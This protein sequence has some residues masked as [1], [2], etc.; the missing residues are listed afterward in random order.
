MY[1]YNIYI[2]CVYIIY[3]MYIYIYIIYIYIYTNVYGHRVPKKTEAV[4]L[5]SPT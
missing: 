3:I 4:D 1:M 5:F 2:L